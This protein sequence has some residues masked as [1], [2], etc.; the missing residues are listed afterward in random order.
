MNAV[1]LYPFTGFMLL[2]GSCAMLYGLHE[3]SILLFL[4]GFVLF[5]FGF[6]ITF[7]VW[8]AYREEFS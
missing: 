5:F 3:G 4:E 8:N 7:Q 1:A 2:F 6:R